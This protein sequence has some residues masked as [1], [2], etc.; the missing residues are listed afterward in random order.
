MFIAPSMQ[1]VQYIKT[2]THCLILHPIGRI[3]CPL[4]SVGALLST[5]ESKIITEVKTSL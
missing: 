1:A 5:R 3:L 4:F 2:Y